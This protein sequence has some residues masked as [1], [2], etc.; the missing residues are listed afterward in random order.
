M[1][2]RSFKSFELTNKDA[3][4]YRVWNDKNSP[5]HIVTNLNEAAEDIITEFHCRGIVLQNKKFADTLEELA[6]HPVTT[7]VLK[8]CNLRDDEAIALAGFIR[9]HSHLAKVRIT[10]DQ[11]TSK[12]VETLRSALAHVS[13]LKEVELVSS[14]GFVA[15]IQK[16][17]MQVIR[18]RLSL[19][20]LQIK[21]PS[22]DLLREKSLSSIAESPESTSSVSTISD[23]SSESDA[24]L[25]ESPASSLKSPI[26]IGSSLF[27]LSPTTP[28]KTPQA[29][30]VSPTALS[31]V[32]SL[33]PISTGSEEFDL[34]DG[35][36]SVARLR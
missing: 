10:K 20:N 35:W 27:S 5:S 29:P 16:N 34:S 7:L 1:D 30:P 24:S 12:G 2:S 26:S 19:F 25:P 11:I 4:E 36:V 14:E 17:M 3:I 15:H 8:D 23:S 31:A 32:E 9:I 22:R 33:S 28:P 13:K 18:Q 6:M 21:I